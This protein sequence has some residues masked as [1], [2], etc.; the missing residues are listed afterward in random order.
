LAHFG[1]GACKDVWV[2][3]RAIRGFAHRAPCRPRPPSPASECGRSKAKKWILRSTPPPTPMASPKSTWA[4]PGGCSILPVPG[5]DGSPLLLPVAKNA[6]HGGSWCYHS[7]SVGHKRERL[8]HREIRLSR[9]RRTSDGSAFPWRPPVSPTRRRPHWRTEC[10]PGRAA[11]PR[12]RTHGRDA[13]DVP[14]CIFEIF[15]RFKPNEQAYVRSSCEQWFEQTL[16]AVAAD[17]RPSHHTC[18]RGAAA[19]ALG[20]AP[21]CAASV[22]LLARTDSLSMSKRTGR[23]SP[24]TRNPGSAIPSERPYSAFALVAP[25]PGDIF[26]EPVEGKAATGDKKTEKA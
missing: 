12:S 11:L 24:V 14:S 10:R 6:S 9:L 15:R 20:H 5:L 7:R 19:H 26:R 3:E 8:L 4:C 18:P 23:R 1:K 13:R 22:Q 25:P 16:E 2:R 21:T 17:F